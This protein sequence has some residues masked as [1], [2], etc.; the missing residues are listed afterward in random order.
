MYILAN[1][2]CFSKDVSLT[3]PFVAV[4]AREHRGVTRLMS[5]LALKGVGAGQ[6]AFLSLL[7]A[8]M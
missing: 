3:I 7:R 5:F 4:E 1:M 8:Q 2:T 6:P